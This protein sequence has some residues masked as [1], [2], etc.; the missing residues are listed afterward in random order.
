MIAT[1]QTAMAA[2][3]KLPALTTCATGKTNVSM[4]THQRHVGL[5]IE[6]ASGRTGFTHDPSLYSLAVSEWVV[7]SMNYCAGRKWVQWRWVPCGKTAKHEHQGSHYCGIHHPALKDQRDNKRKAKALAKWDARRD[8]GARIVRVREAERKV[9]EAAEAWFEALPLQQSYRK[10]D[11]LEQAVHAL[12][13][14][15]HGS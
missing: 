3:G 15:R 2:A 7:S 10:Q 12:R 4:A 6:M 13:E 14:A 1:A 11:A 5:A 8:Y 9:I